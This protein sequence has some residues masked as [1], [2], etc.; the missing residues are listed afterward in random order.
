MKIANLN[1]RATLIISDTAGADISTLSGGLFGPSMQSIYDAW[2]EFSEWAQTIT[3]PVAD[4]DVTA[5]DLGSP[6]PRP[7]QVFAVG[8]NYSEHANESG[9]ALPS[10]PPIFT[11][12]ASC[13][14][15][16]DTVVALPEGGHTDWEVE[17]VV[18]IGKAARSVAEADAW[19]YVAGLTVGQD[20]SE[21]I[22]QMVAPA[23]QFSMGKSLP[24]FGPMGPWLVTPDEF[25][26]PD[27]LALSAFIDDEIMQKSRTRFLIFSVSE[28]IAY[29]SGKLQLYPGD[30]I[31]TGTPSGVGLGRSPQVWLEPGQTLTSTIEGIG[32]IT[33]RFE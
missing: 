19:T 16:P 25:E 21:R 1:N 12:F 28:L 26:N 10:E 2:E 14:T 9:F 29:L 11:K 30:V 24:G 18:V 8:L 7:A 3:V 22:L 15:G 17:L 23:K 31:F 33:Q 13:I 6:S 5:G 20:I 32:T 27:D 4:V